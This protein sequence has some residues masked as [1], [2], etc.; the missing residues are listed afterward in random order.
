M[1]G[2]ERTTT[3]DDGT[4]NAWWPFSVKDALREKIVSVLVLAK[5]PARVDRLRKRLSGN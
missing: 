5:I 4:L 1:S 3:N 2:L